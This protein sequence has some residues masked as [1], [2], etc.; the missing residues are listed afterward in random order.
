MNCV[1]FNDS[2]HVSDGI[3]TEKFE[4][5]PHLGQIF[6]RMK[7][8]HLCVVEID[9]LI[10]AASENAL[11]KKDGIL[12][13]KF[14]E[15]YKGDYVLQDE[16]IGQNI[17]QVAGIK[18]EKVKEIYSLIP[19]GKVATFVPY[20]IAVRNL[21]LRNKIAENKMVVFLDDFGHEKLI[22]VFEGMKFSRTRTVFHAEAEQILPEIKR[23]A[24]NYEKK[25]GY[26]GEDGFVIVTNNEKLCHEFKHMEKGLM[27]QVVDSP[28]PSLD[29][30]RMGGFGL[31]YILQEEIIKRRRQ[32][33]FYKWRRCLSISAAVLVIGIF[34]NCYNRVN[35]KFSQNSLDRERYR[36]LR[37][38]AIL[39]QLDPQVYHAVLQQQKRINYALA[40]R[41]VFKALPA[42]YTTDS[43][44]FYEQGRHWTMEA[45]L[46]APDHGLI[47]SIPAGGVLQRGRIRDFIINGKPGKYLRIDL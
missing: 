16:K 41:N 35:F 26:K 21:L 10:A 9:V 39:D 24:I 17:F 46:Y 34:F 33:E 30:L 7:E 28:Y 38:G 15:Y 13:L 47:S 4:K 3:K 36:N 31:K 8:V 11:D 20:A 45:Y 1:L 27:T 44:K 42:G 37:L 2:I 29:G 32:E 18:S 25:M 43:L 6:S 22:T 19:S 40:Y 12:S 23:S 14:S 5:G